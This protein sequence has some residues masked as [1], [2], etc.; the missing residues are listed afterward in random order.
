MK[1]YGCKIS[2]YT[3]KLEAYLRYRSLTYT[4]LPLVGEEKKL[5]KN[6][7]ASQMPVVELD[8][9]RWITDSSPM[10]AWLDSE[11]NAASIY[12]EDHILRFAALMVEDYADEW[13]WRPAMHYR[14]SYR[15]SRNYA[16]QAIYED[17]IEGRLQ[18][19]RF[20]ALRRIKKRQLGEFVKGDGV[21]KRSRAHCDQTYLKAL[22]LLEAIFKKRPF[23]MGNS[24]TIADFGMMGPM[25]RH[26]G[27][28]P[29]P[30]E[31]MRE[32]APGVYEWVA[33]VWNCK[34]DDIMPNLIETV[35]DALV[36]LLIEC[37][38]TS[39]AQHRQNAQAFGED[40]SRFDMDIQGTTYER[41]P[42][43]RYRVWCLEELRREWNMLEHNAQEK[44]KRILSSSKAKI[45]WDNSEFSRSEYDTD[46]KAP[47]NKA[48][49]VFGNGIPPR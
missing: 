21:N 38:E 31:I 46:R 34:G 23:I 1:V 4:N 15:S 36:S 3:G 49:N 20:L 48:I 12:P 11:H 35:D 28:D 7:G 41:V 14:W 25:F 8:D 17:Q 26:F 29:Y 19:P 9:G 44:L 22:D 45:L 27:M 47:F 43:S 6:A 24:P 33:R 40:L 32:R 18:I 16:A 5:R 30:A 13:L 42:S 2:Y 39:L 10:I 37:C